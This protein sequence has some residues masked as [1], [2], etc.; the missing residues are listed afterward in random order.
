MV[1][2][3]YLFPL[4]N[5]R[6]CKEKFLQLILHQAVTFLLCIDPQIPLFTFL[7]VNK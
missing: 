4:D 2:F 5:K 1:Y 6:E 7:L 3:I